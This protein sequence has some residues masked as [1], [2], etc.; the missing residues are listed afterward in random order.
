MTS[1]I[2]NNLNLKYQRM[3]SS[4]CKNIGIKNRYVWQR[5][6]Y[7]YVILKSVSE[8]NELITILNPQKTGFN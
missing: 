1:V 5:L 6:N 8:L 3:T 4:G 2:S 7:F